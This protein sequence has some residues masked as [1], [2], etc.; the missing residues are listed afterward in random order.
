[1]TPSTSPAPLDAAALAALHNAA[2]I[3]FS[4]AR[5]AEDNADTALRRAREAREAAEAAYNEVCAAV[6]ALSGGAR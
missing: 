5:T 2:A 1:M 6:L 3:A 4:A